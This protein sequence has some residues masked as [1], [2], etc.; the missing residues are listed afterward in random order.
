MQLPAEMLEKAKIFLQ[1]LTPQ[2]KK[3]LGIDENTDLEKMT[4]EQMKNLFRKVMQRRGGPRPAG[5]G[6]K[7]PTA[8]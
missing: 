2:Q 3:E 4:A 8:F 6:E 1:N 7:S 5:E